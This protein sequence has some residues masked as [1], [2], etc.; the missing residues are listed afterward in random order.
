MLYIML[1]QE[2]REMS[3][4]TKKPIRS[5]PEG[6]A[7]EQDANRIIHMLSR[8]DVIGLSHKWAESAYLL[9]S[10][11]HLNTLKVA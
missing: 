5:G 1:V 7:T 9:H 6:H 3:K 11:A 4:Y 8:F 2:L 10:A